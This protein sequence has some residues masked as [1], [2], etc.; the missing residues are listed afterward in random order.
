MDEFKTA[1]LGHEQFSKMLA[2][3]VPYFI[4]ITNCS[5]GGAGVKMP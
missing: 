2:L 4:I 5:G 3:K 1:C